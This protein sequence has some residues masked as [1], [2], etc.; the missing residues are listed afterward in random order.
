MLAIGTTAP[1]FRLPSLTG[2]SESLTAQSK[3]M[4]ATLVNFWYLNCPPCR[5]E[6]PEFEKL[7][8][9][10]HAQGFNIVAID[11][12]DPPAAVTTYIRHAG[13]TYPILLGGEET[14]K[15]IFARYRV[16][17]FPATYLLDA[18][19]HIVYRATGEDIAGLRQALKQ[20]GFN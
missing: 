15:S 13:L 6:N 2:A 10:F 12:G 1:S 8:Q 11:K 9:Q 18:N 5:L 4:K 17:T 7:Y 20:L 3:G 19:G 14:P 16:S